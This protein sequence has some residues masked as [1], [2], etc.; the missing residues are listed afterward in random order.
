MAVNV[1]VKLLRVCLCKHRIMGVMSPVWEFGVTELFNQTPECV[2]SSTDQ[3]VS[4]VSLVF[5]FFVN[6]KPNQVKLS[7]SVQPYL[8]PSQESDLQVWTL[9]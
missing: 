5:F 6:L 4:G 3:L 7:Q 8:G 9:L 1:Q 2:C